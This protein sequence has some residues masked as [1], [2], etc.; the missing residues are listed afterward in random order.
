MPQ[1]YLVGLS[2]DRRDNEIA[3]SISD[4]EGEPMSSPEAGLLVRQE[5]EP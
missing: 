2:I 3:E 5:E 4:A 1:R